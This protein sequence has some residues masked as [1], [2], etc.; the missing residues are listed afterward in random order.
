MEYYK[1]LNIPGRTVDC[2]IMTKKYMLITKQKVYLHQC[3]PN[4]QIF[5]IDKTLLIPFI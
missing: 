3:A 4:D 2:F 5:S 1:T